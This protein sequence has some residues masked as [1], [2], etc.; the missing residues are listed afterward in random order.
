MVQKIFFGEVTNK[1]SEIRVPLNTQLMLAV[2]VGLI[3]FFG[4]YPKPMINLTTDT[5]NAIVAQIK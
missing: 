5:V 2:L 4:V 3:L 1:E